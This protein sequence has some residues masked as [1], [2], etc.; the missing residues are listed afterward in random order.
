[1]FWSLFS[2]TQVNSQTWSET[3]KL[4]STDRAAFDSFG[5]SVSIDGNYAIIGAFQEDEDELG[6]NTINNS[7]AAYI[8]EKNPSGNWLQGQKIVASDRSLSDSFG[9]SVAINGDYL[10]VGSRYDDEDETGGNTLSN[11]GSAYIFE[12]DINNVWIEKQKIVANDRGVN[13]LF[14]NS[15]SIS[16]DSIVV[17]SWQNNTDSNNSNFKQDAGAAYIF[18]RDVNN[19]W[20]QTQKI[21][22][23]HRGEDDLFGNSVSIDGNYLIVGAYREDE[24]LTET[25]N[26]LSN[27]G[28]AYVFLRDVSGSWSQTDKLIPSDRA[29]DDLFGGGVAIN[30]NSIVVSAVYEDEDVTGMNTINNSGSVY[31]YELNTSNVWVEKQKLVSSDRQANDLFGGAIAI[32]G[33]YIII[34]THYEDEDSSGLN[35][36]ES[37][38]SAYLFE[39]SISNVWIEK[40]KIAPNIRASYDWF[41]SSVAISGDHAIVGAFQEDEDE[42]GNNLL[43]N[44][45]STYIFEYT[46]ALG[47]NDNN[48][49]MDIIYYPNPTTGEVNIDLGVNYTDVQVTLV[50]V[51][52]QKLQVKK[53]SSTQYLGLM[54]NGEPG[55]YFIELNKSGRKIATLKIIK[56]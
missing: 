21:T 15:V 11:A 8:F 25:N 54:I 22:S 1:M 27:A 56:E 32:H 40:Q 6:G 34:G 41:G 37:S 13:D 49:K 38:G 2:I 10:I 23:S 55:L 5:I 9:I 47:I 39:R 19:I 35:T 20:N 26:W 53:Y 18:E 28:A 14:G 16:D 46:P 31:V 33:D 52:G 36:L 48:L 45:G 12:R 43:N 7:G 51:L 24:D 3:Q 50:D 17:G 29:T 44:S 42:S 4:V 30:G